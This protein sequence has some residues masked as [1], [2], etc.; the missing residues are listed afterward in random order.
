MSLLAVFA[1]ERLVNLE[2]EIVDGVAARA[3]G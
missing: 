2:V 1:K 3:A